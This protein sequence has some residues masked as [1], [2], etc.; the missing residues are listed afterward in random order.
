MENTIKI[1][2]KNTSFWLVGERRGNRLW[3]AYLV[4]PDTSY[5]EKIKTNISTKSFTLFSNVILKTPFPCEAL[6][7]E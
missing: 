7:T 1:K 6:K 4:N 3:D 5:K 2:I